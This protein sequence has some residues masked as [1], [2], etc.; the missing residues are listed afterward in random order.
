[1]IEEYLTEHPGP[2]FASEIAHALGL[3]FG[4]TFMATHK[5]LEDGHIKKA[6]K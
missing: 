2:I 6:K 1:M 4:V 3:D 5:L